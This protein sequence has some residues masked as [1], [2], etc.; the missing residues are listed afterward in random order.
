MTDST[1]KEDLSQYLAPTPYIDS[2]HPHIVQKAAELAKGCHSDVEK[3]RVLYNFVRDSYTREAVDSF[4]AS[5]VFDQGGNSCYQRSILLTALC[6]SVGI[7]ARLHLQKV[8]IKSWRNLRDG[9]VKDISFAH[10]LT[11]IYLN[12]TWN[13]YEATGNSYKWFQFTGEEKETAEMVVKFDA[14]RDCLF[15][16]SRNS[17][18]TGELLPMHFADRTEEME[19]IIEQMMN[20]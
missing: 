7:P 10:G 5:E 18:V 14:D 4:V 3:A 13:V 20:F 1:L 12:G 16:I 19:K 8:S 11:G 17:R 2:D 9:Q 6:R 15:D